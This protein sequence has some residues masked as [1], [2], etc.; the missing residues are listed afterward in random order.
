LVNGTAPELATTGFAI[1]VTDKE[2]NLLAW[3]HGTPPHWITDAAGAEAW[4][5]ALALKICPTAPAIVTDCKGLL[6]EAAAATTNCKG[7]KK[8]ARTWKHIREACDGNTAQLTTSRR[9]DWMPAHSSSSSIGAVEKAS[10]KR[11]TAIDWRANNLADHLARQAAEVNAPPR[12]TIRLVKD[13]VEMVK[14]AAAKLG[15]VT[16]AANN[17]SVLEVQPDGS[18]RNVVKRDA[19]DPPPVHRKKNSKPARAKIPCQE[20]ADLSMPAAPQ[21][22]ASKMHATAKARAAS[23]RAAT[24]REQRK[25][26]AA[27]SSIITSKTGQHPSQ[28][29]KPRKRRNTLGKHPAASCIHPSPVDAASASNTQHAD[30]CSTNSHSASSHCVSI[31]ALQHRA[32]EE[33]SQAAV[34]VQ[35]VQSASISGCREAHQNSPLQVQELFM[36]SGVTGQGSVTTMLASGDNLGD[37][38]ELASLEADGVPVTWPRWLPLEQL[39]LLRA[40]FS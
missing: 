14:C 37:L 23:K 1:V 33:P 5:L 12:K 32:P 8:L 20:P 29:R 18:T 24:A 7:K 9:L 11:V 4:A 17:C 25:Q 15:L 27:L 21:F 13:A 2:S 30:A 6:T 36:G 22:P 3:G 34:V 31:P 39:L 19:C 40:R 28:P 16:W 38:L 10:G 26:E 35:D